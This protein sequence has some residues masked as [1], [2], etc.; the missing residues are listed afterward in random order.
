MATSQQADDT[1]GRIVCAAERCFARQG[2]DGTGVATICASA[3]V[4][5]G[6]FYHHFASKRALFL[7]VMERRFAAFEEAL[8]AAGQATLPV[9]DQLRQMVDL[10]QLAFEQNDQ[11]MPLFLEFWT[12]AL[13]DPAVR[14]A[15]LAPY[16]VYQ[17]FFSQL[18]ERGVREGSLREID[19]ELGAQ[20]LVLLG[21]GL[22]LQG[23]LDPEA[24]RGEH[25]LREGLE[26]LLNALERRE[27]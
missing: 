10:L 20:V 23:L 4:S 13:R 25:A 17:R 8:M 19:P 3:S 11:D 9:P 1:R 27:E 6:A 15:T 24:G 12:Q 2:Y 7:A 26:L 16:R 14:Q 22:F 5:K 18:V 21:S